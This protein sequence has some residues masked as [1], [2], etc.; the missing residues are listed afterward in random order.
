MRATNRETLA[1]YT[2]HLKW[3]YDDSPDKETREQQLFVG[4]GSQQIDAHGIIIFF[5]GIS[6]HYIPFLNILKFIFIRK[7]LS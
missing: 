7:F 1:D 5:S 3:F 4:P 2:S 6:L